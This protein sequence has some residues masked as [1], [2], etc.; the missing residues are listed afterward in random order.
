M[1]GRPEDFRCPPGVADQEDYCFRLKNFF[2]GVRYMSTVWL[3]PP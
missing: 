1:G 3:R 2:F